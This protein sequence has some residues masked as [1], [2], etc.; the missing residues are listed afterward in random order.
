MPGFVHFLRCVGKAAVKHGVRALAG[1]VPMG[2]ELYD[3][4]SDALADYR[5]DGKDEQLRAE[6]QALAQAGPAETKQAAEQ[7]VREVAA[8]QSP[9]VQIALTSYLSQVP[10]AVRQSLRRPA[11]PTGT[12]VPATLA[13]NKPEN[14][15]P[16]LPARLPRFKPGDCP[17]GVGD[18]ELVELLG[19][20]GF[21]EVWKARHL[22]LA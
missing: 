21:G 1:L 5:R 3:I 14:L 7:V 17:P 22:T 11:D 15:L 16:F 4:A 8:G 10:A 20:G 6:I 13:L 12:T 19:V 9:K 18:W 2:G